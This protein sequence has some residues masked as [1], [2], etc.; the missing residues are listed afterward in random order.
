MNVFA[1]LPEHP[2]G[3]EQDNLP[4]GLALD[5]EGN[6]WV[7]HYGMHAIRKISPEGKLLSSINTTLPFT[8]NVIFV[9]ENDLMITGGY[10]EPGPGALFNIALT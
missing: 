8:S 6:L 5:S 1:Q 7:A 3:N 10:G 4:D 9:D 2:S